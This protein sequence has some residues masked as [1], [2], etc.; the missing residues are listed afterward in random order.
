MP[1]YW[2][3]TRLRRLI[4]IP[5][6]AFQT[7][8]RRTTNSSIWRTSKAQQGGGGRADGRRPGTGFV[9]AVPVHRNGGLR[10]LAV[11]PIQ[12]PITWSVTVLDTVLRWMA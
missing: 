1:T 3:D 9:T 7:V 6:R 12:G 4:E 10:T 2:E 5:T 8:H 11:I